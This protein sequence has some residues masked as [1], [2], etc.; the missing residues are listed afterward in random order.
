MADLGEVGKDLRP[1][2]DALNRSACS[3]GAI[4][5]DVLENVLQPA[6]GLLGP[7]YF[8]HERMRC[9]IPSFEMVRF[10]SESAI[11]RSTMT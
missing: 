9:A 6:L 10:A 5:R 2:V 8:C 1:L 11:P 4:R 3:G 7:C